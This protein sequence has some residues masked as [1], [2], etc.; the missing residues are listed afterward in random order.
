MKNDI[1]EILI[2]GFAMVFNF[3]FQVYNRIPAHKLGLQF[4]RLICMVVHI[5]IG[6]VYVASAGYLYD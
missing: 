3:V 5:A 4:I 1:K 2:I 6:T